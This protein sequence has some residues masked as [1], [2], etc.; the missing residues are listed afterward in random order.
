MHAIVYAETHTRTHARTRTLAHIRT[1]AEE[2]VS[3]RQRYQTSA[4]AQEAEPVPELRMR[5]RAERTRSARATLEAALVVRN[6]EIGPGPRESGR[7]RDTLRCLGRDHQGG[8]ANDDAAEIPG[9]CNQNRSRKCTPSR[10]ITGG[11][12]A[13]AC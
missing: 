12:R 4:A 1:H 8:A 13:N 5:R 11:S 2:R 3:E 6:V 9:S 7:V 10:R